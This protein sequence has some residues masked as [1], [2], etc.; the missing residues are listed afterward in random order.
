MS[1]LDK[2]L[3]DMEQALR[4]H[5]A[6]SAGRV[7][8]KQQVAATDKLLDLLEGMNLREVEFVGTPAA[9]R[10]RRTLAVV[11]ACLRPT[12]GPTTRVQRALDRVFDLQKALFTRHAR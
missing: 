11:P 10:I 2:V 7:R 6:R 4:E 5:E 9:T 8:F 3:E 1:E 12:V